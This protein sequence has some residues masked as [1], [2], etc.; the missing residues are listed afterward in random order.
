MYNKSNARNV[1]DKL[2]KGAIKKQ[3]VYGLTSKLQK[4]KAEDKHVHSLRFQA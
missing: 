4:L 2:S 3:M 1:P